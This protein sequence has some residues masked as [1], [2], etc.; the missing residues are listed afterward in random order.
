M[1]TFLLCL[2]SV[3]FVQ[4]VLAQGQLSGTGYYGGM[5]NCSPQM[6]PGSQDQD[7][8]A[9]EL[10]QELKDFKSD[11]SKMKSKLSSLRTQISS[12]KDLVKLTGFQGEAFSL[13][14]N[15]ISGNY[16]CKSYQSSCRSANSNFSRVQSS[17]PA[18]REGVPSAP[19]CR[20]DLISNEPFVPE[21]LF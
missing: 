18:A 8:G 19:A 16:T 13:I 11:L 5:Q 17:E 9:K 14:E 2:P 21:V 3:F 15:H 1:R 7:D 4:V 20:E 10:Q 6:A 12:K